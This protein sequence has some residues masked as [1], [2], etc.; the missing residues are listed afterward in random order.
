MELTGKCK[1][2]YTKW[3]SDYSESQ[4]YLKG[5][6]EY[7]NYLDEV[8]LPSILELSLLVKF[9]DVAE[10]IT[11]IEYLEHLQQWSGKVKDY[12]SKKRVDLNL[13]TSREK[14]LEEAVT[15]ANIIYNERN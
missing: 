14:A 5:W 10:I 11:T 9:F 8:E 15:T 7:D 4:H 13:H 2:N 1:E 6:R 12:I 3:L